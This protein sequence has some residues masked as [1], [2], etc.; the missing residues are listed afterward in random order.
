VHFADK[1]INR[2]NKIQSHLVIGIDPDPGRLFGDNSRFLKACPNKEHEFVL[3]AFVDIMIQAAKNC[4]CAVKPQSAFFE[5]MG[6]TGLKVLSYC[7]KEARKKEIPVILDA[8]R[9]D[10]GNTAKAYAAAYLEPKSMFFSDALT[11]NPFLGPDTLKPFVE[12][13]ARSGSGI[14]VLVKTTNPSSGTFQDATLPGGTTVSHSIAM[15]IQ[16]E[17]ENYIGSYGYSHVGAVVGATYPEHVAGLRKALPNSIMLLPGYGAQ[18]ATVK[19]VKPAFD[20]SG[21][22]AIISSSRSIIFAYEKGETIHQSL[23]DIYEQVLMA[24][25]FQKDN[26]EAVARQV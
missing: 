7:I 19:D 14:F 6:L 21:Q 26:I 23:Q 25:T 1:L 2:I 8:K 13:A 16:K 24:A 3:T 20:K 11:V 17:G 4:A 5:S 10:I 12:T 9:G 22:G 18:G 15:V